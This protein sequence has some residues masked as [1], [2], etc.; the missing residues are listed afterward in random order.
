M[1]CYTA[2]VDKV[3]IINIYAKFI[4]FYGILFHSIRYPVV[5]TAAAITN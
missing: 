5:L 3:Y 1:N 4:S 2:P